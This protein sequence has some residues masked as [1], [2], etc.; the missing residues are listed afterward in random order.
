MLRVLVNLSWTPD[1]QPER[2][3]APKGSRAGSQKRKRSSWKGKRQ[4]IARRRTE[5]PSWAK[6]VAKDC[7]KN[8][9]I[10]VVGK[11]NRWLN[12]CCW[13]ESQLACDRTWRK[14]CDCFCAQADDPKNRKAKAKQARAR[15]DSGW[16]GEAWAIETN[17]TSILDF[18]RAL[19]RVCWA[20]HCPIPYSWRSDRE[21][22]WAAWWTHEAQ[23]KI[24]EDWHQRR[25]LRANSV[26]LGVLQQ[27]QRV[28]RHASI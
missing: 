4:E 24:D 3:V 14:A 10:R 25:E 17:K 1:P 2:K 26:H 16:A 19:P 22:A 6:R 23:A 5:M 20:Q 12:R 7:D 8:A 11:K 9:A 27:F 18:R 13:V 15:F 21:N 28:P